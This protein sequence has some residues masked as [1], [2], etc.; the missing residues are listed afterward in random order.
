V[1]RGEG[2]MPLGLDALAQM[3]LS[4]VLARVP[5]RV[6]AGW[7]IW[8]DGEQ[9]FRIPE[10]VA[11]LGERAVCV[12]SPAA[13][14]DGIL[15][16]AARAPSFAYHPATRFAG[17]VRDPIGRAV[18]VRAIAGGTVLELPADL[19]VGCDGRGSSVR[20]HAK[21]T[22]TPTPES[23]DVLWFKAPSPSEHAADFHMMVRGGQ[24]PLIAYTSW[25]DQLQCGVIMPNGGLAEFR[26]QD[27]LARALRAAPD[28]LAGHV[29]DHQHAVCGP[30]RLN[31][32]VAHARSWTVPGVLLLGDAAHPMSP[33]RAQGIN[34][35]LRDAIV[36]AN[37]LGP[38]AAG[39]AEPSA[40]DR[41]CAAI[42][43]ERQPEI[44]RA[45]RL[46]RREATGQVDARAA[47]WRFALA[48][49][50]A[51]AVG[52]HRWAQRAWLRRQAG[53]RFGTS[54]V[55]LRQVEHDGSRFR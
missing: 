3:G 36:A 37:H 26:G 2:L 12:V 28:R 24:H 53:L 6:V 40:V 13:L 35:A 34:L 32:L 23:Y 1:F 20:T 44:Q 49:H 21:L 30:V 45:Q 31:V 50:G 51:R 29:L 33:V 5:G 54:Q 18:G 9:V 11:E 7:R 46:Q 16:E 10:P 43:A 39:P 55:T 42:Q 25:D 4:G 48:K 15:A 47:T 8:I 19:V 52:R 27:W 38:L 41:A 17:V 14:L 22:L